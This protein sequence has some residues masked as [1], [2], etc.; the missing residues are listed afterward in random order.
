MVVVALVVAVVP[1]ALMTPL[2][3][4]SYQTL[5]DECYAFVKKDSSKKESLII[6]APSCTSNFSTILNKYPILKLFPNSTRRV[7]WDTKLGFYRHSLTMP[8][9]FSSPDFY[10]I[11]HLAFAT[12]LISKILSCQT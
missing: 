6:P 12:S 1:V 2:E 9:S 4:P 10:E 7:K 5:M 8:I 3:A 11:Y